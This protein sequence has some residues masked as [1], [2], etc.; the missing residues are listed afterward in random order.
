M[1]TLWHFHTLL[2]A[3]I[4]ATHIAHAQPIHVGAGIYENQPMV[5]LDQDGKAAG[6]QVDVLD[7]IAQQENWEIEYVFGTWQECLERLDRGEIDLLLDIGYSEERAEKM[8]FSSEAIISTWAQIYTQPGSDMRFIPDL[9]GK[10]IAVMRND[11]HALPLQRLLGD[12]GIT[13]NYVEFDDYK[14]SMQAVE[15][16]RVDAG[17]FSRIAGLRLESTYGVRRSPIVLDPIQVRIAFPKGKNAEIRDAIDGNLRKQKRDPD[18]A[19][20]RAVD[21]WLGRV[22]P[23]EMPWW[24]PWA[25]G[26]GLLG[27]VSAISASALMRREVAR[28]TAELRSKNEELEQE[29]GSRARVENILQSGRDRMATQSRLLMT[30]ARS[31]AI[32][33]GDLENALRQITSAAVQTLEVERASVWLLEEGNSR[34]RCICLY[35]AATGDFADGAFLTRADYPS[36]F[37]ALAENRIIAASDAHKDPRTSE[38]SESYLTALNIN[39]MLDAPIRMGQRLGGIL[40]NEHV[41][42][43]REWHPDEEYFAASLAD[44]VALALEA[45]E[46]NAAEVRLRESEERNRLVLEKAL[47][48]VI[49]TDEMANVIGWNESAEETFGY[50]RGEA[51]GQPVIKLIVPRA[52]YAEVAQEFLEFRR[53]QSGTTRKEVLAKKKNGDEFYAE[54]SVSV[55]NQGSQSIFTAFVRDLTEQ[56]RAHQ[57]KER[58]TQIQTEM[59]LARSIQRSFLP[60]HFPAFPE[61]SEFEI[62]AEMVPATDVGGDFF[63]FY[64]LDD[65]RLAFAIGDVSGKGVPGALVMAMTLTILKAS[66]RSAASV[67]DCLT[68][69]NRQL[70][71]ENETA[72]FVTM[73]YGVLHISSGKIVY[74]IAGHPPPFLVSLEGSVREM[75]AYGGLILGI[76]GDAAYKEGELYLTHGDCFVIYTDGVTEAMDADHNLYDESRLINVLGRVNSHN[77]QLT[78][79][80][81]LD[82]VN[83]FSGRAPRHDDITLLALKWNA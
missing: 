65:D 72:F 3:C 69:L 38:F 31:D 74:S 13:A 4:C 16:R 15:H 8:D 51:I 26:L 75:E 80:L 57:M 63:D 64:L 76:D 78:T 46:R 36:Y 12:F 53:T 6:L 20:N 68:Q 81:I 27:V 25:L 83:A 59:E 28:K 56:K 71:E 66:A 61:R 37:K 30:L 45:H 22:M 44:F 7:D 33:K 42:P 49:I 35:N 58:L 77:A 79:K 32:G 50:T 23:E 73:V 47:D 34:I 29:V 82:D 19:Y 17:L 11:V 70:S 18:S 5:F 60:Q 14:D 41:G 48:A 39:S 40:C 55:A 10:T 52:L 21:R 9:E 67:A 24:I 54:F 43:A 1:S 2:A 62:Y